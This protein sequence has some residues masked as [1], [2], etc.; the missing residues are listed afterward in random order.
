[1]PSGHVEAKVDGIIIASSDT[2]ELVEGN[3]YFPPSSVKS[4]YLTKTDLHTHCPWKGDA[5][6]YSLKVGDKE[7]ANAA[8]YYPEP[9][10]KA[11]HIKH[12]VAFYKTKVDVSSG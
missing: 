1:M 4:E 11:A 8:W 12:H 3:V 10:E 5:S 6:Y 2:Y 9:F 7:L